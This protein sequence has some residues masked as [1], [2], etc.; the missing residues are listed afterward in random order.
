MK[1]RKKFEH[2][3]DTGG[4]YEIILQKV[5]RKYGDIRIKEI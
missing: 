4:K 1:I 2:L 5:K 3:L